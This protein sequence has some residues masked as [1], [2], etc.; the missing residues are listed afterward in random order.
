MSANWTCCPQP[1]LQ[2]PHLN[3]I[4]EVSVFVQAEAADI[5]HEVELTIPEGT[6]VTIPATKHVSFIVFVGHDDRV[7]AS[8][9]HAPKSVAVVFKN[10]G[11]ETELRELQQGESVAVMWP[12]NELKVY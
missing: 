10:K 1:Q 6:K 5:R 11:V 7:V 8:A 4:L 3:G 9:T 2:V 12:A